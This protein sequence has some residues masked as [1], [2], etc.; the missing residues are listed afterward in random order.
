LR[1]A[2]PPLSPALSD[3]EQTPKNITAFLLQISWHHLQSLHC[4]SFRMDAIA[5]SADISRIL[6]PECQASAK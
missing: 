4:G 2:I 6:L 1:Q 3:D 5:A